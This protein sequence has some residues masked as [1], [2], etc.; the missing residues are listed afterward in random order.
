MTIGLF[1]IIGIPLPLISYGGL[2]PHFYRAYFYPCK[3]RC[4]QANG[5]SLTALN[6]LQNFNGRSRR[7][8]LYATALYGSLW[9]LVLP[10]RINLFMAFNIQTFKTRSLSA[11][12]FVAIMLCG[13]LIN[14]WTFFLL[15]SIIHLG[16][17]VEYQKLIGVIDADY[18]DISS[19]HKWG[20]VMLGWSFMMWM[21]NDAY[22]IFP[23]L[24][25]LRSV[26]G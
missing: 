19:F 12:V 2:R 9:C 4:R 3:T 6:L 7:A 15:F 10:K 16:C 17:W 11:V 24:T 26:G 14:Q 5:T 21:T 1:P 25:L 18:K 20:V 23:G 22:E 8:Y 13:V